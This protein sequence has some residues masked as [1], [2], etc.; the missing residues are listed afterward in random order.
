MQK[1]LCFPAILFIALL[2]KGAD[3]AASS[4]V[5]N[6]LD[7]YVTKRTIPKANHYR[8]ATMG[9]QYLTC[10]AMTFY[11]AVRGLAHLIQLLDT[12][13]IAKM[14]LSISN[15]NLDPPDYKPNI[16]VDTIHLGIEMTGM[17][18]SGYIL[19][20][21]VHI[22]A[23]FP[24]LGGVDILI[25]HCIFFFY[26]LISSLY[27]AFP[28][29]ACWLLTGE[30]STVIYNIRWAII[31]TGYGHTSALKYVQIAFAVAFMIRFV[32]YSGGLYYHLCN[33]HLTPKSVPGWAVITLTT[34]Q[35]AG[36]FLNLFWLPK[37]IRLVVRPVKNLKQA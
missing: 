19:A 33:V 13:A 28:L 12:P 27:G 26:G 25:H 11:V 7:T 8:L 17:I 21:F 20:D 15:F 9:H 18:F 5:A 3:L 1:Y 23:T 36:F 29:A 10:T 22:V 37:V 34:I 2:W 24:S 4:I 31:N 35:V 16:H 30:I 6:V 14:H 32:I